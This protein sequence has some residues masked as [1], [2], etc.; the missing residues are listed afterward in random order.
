MTESKCKSDQ[1]AGP[2]QP[3]GPVAADKVFEG[4]ETARADV[5]GELEPV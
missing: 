1:A 5:R 4:L 2:C 3:F